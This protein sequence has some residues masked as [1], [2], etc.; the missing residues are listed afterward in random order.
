[1]DA[2]EPLTPDEVAA[3]FAGLDVPWWIAGGWA[4]D[5]FLGRTTR[6]HGDID[7]AVLRRDWPTVRAH[8]DGWDLL[9]N[10]HCVWCRPTPGEPWRVQLLLEES[11]GD[12]WV[13]RR[14]PR[15]QR[16]LTSLGDGHVLAP[17]VQ[18]LY[19]SGSTAAKDI[20]DVTA[21]LPVLGAPARTWLDDVLVITRSKND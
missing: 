7:I 2:W 16:P 9:V 12:D 18:L 14:D 20:A 11:E 6:T 19:K 17:E 4:V 13:Y 3:L 15:V 8:L 10:G 1:M 5:L 21:V